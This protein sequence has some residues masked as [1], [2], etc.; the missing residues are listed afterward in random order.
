MNRIGKI[1]TPALL[2]TIVVL[3]VKSLITPLGSY[4]TPTESYAT[5]GTAF[6]QGFLDGYNTLDALASFVFGILVIDL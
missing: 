6:L 3:I 2:L 5:S 4:G 1:L